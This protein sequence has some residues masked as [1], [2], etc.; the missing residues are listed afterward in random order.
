VESKRNKELVFSYGKIVQS[1]RYSIGKSSGV[2]INEDSVVKIFNLRSKSIKP[3]RGSYELCWQRETECLRRLKGYLH[4]P[5][6]IEAYD[7]HLGLKMTNTGESLFDTWQEHNLMLYLD[8][9]HRIADTLEE[10]RIQYF[11]PGMDPGSKHKQYTKFPLSN[12]TIQ[13]GELSLIDFEMA[14][15]VDSLAETKISDRLRFLYNHYNPNHFRQALVNALEN[16]GE[17]YESELMAKIPNRENFKEIAKQNPRKVWK[18]MT[19]FTQPSDKVVKEWKKYQKRY[20]MD[21]AV[22]RVERMKLAT[23]CKPEHKLVDIGC[24]D[25]FITMLVAP[26]VASATGVEPFVELPDKTGN[27][28]DNVS[29]F[30]STFNDFVNQNTKQYDILLSLA[31]S[32]QLRDFGGLNEQQIVDAYYSLL[33]PGGIVVH[34]TQKLEN[35]PNNQAHTNAMITAFKTKFRQIDHGQARPSGQREYYH[36]QKV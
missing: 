16:P 34:E 4:F 31:V 12:F 27:K 13:D 17:C 2:F 20:G 29:W 8:Q 21:D 10:Q 15:P 35:R 23:I 7:D 22:D 19:T 36:F 32:I 3:A 24:N 18:S 14:N 5:Q 30:R 26:M 1:E 33:A 9:V 25:G 28:P 11:Y 6:L